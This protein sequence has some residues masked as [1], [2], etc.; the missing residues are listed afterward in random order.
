MARIDLSN[1][2]RD[3]RKKIFEIY[4]E[5]RM[6]HSTQIQA[7]SI[8]QLRNKFKVSHLKDKER[9]EAFLNRMLVNEIN[10]IQIRMYDEKRLNK[11]KEKE[12]A[13]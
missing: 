3:E 11:N 8:K 2:T 5:K 10:P 7:I 9:I 6:E 1:K 4:I 12:N 13:N